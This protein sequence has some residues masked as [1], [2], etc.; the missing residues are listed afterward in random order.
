MTCLLGTAT[1]LTQP[2]QVKAT[3]CTPHIHPENNPHSTAFNIPLPQSCLSTSPNFQTQIPFYT[4]KE[5]ASRFSMNTSNPV[6]P[7]LHG[8]SDW[9]A[10][11]GNKTWWWHQE[12]TCQCLSCEYLGHVYGVGVADPVISSVDGTVGDGGCYS[13]FLLIRVLVLC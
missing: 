4:R 7:P 12:R 9:P 10:A 8:R 11:P 1:R 13:M 3:M 2:R 6:A 5:H